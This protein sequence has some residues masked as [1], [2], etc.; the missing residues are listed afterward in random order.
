MYRMAYRS[1]VGTLTFIWKIDQ[2]L[3]D[4]ESCNARAL[5]EVTEILPKYATRDMK[6][7]FIEKY[8]DAAK[9][10]TMVLRSIFQELTEDSSAASSSKEAE[11]DLRAAQFLLYSDHTDI[12][13]DLRS[14]NGQPG[15]TKFDAF[16]DKCQ[17]YF[18][19]HV[20]AVSEQRHGTDY[21]YLPVAISIKDLRQ[22]VKSRLPDLT[23][24]PSSEWLRLLFWPCD[25]DTSRAMHHTGHFNIKFRIQS[26]LVQA[27]HPD[28]KYAA[29]Q[30]KYLKNFAVKFR[31]H[32]LMICLDDKANVPV[33]EPGKPQATGVRGHNRSLAPV[34]GLILSALDYDFH[35]AGIIPSVVFVFDVPSSPLDSFFNGNVFVTSKQ[36]IFEPS[37]PFRHGAEFLRILEDHLYRQ[38]ELRG[39]VLLL[40]TDGGPDHRLT[41]GSVQ[42]SLLCLFLRLNLDMLIAVRTAPGNSWTNL[43]ERVMPVLN[44]ALQNVALERSRMSPQM[45]SLLKSKSTMA[46]VHSA[47]KHFP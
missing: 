4:H 3:P 21:L 38:A 35:L 5:V 37:S 45:E 34:S 32:C 40:Y 22:Q 30:Y 42:I 20:A 15:S 8:S 18:D 29:V 19:E 10:P 47:S 16:W 36:K 39:K 25:P 23:P 27:D 9:C 7:T 1:A 13:L 2:T 24:I 31:E 6:K 33:G 41:Y 44:L 12:I 28:S 17:K 14:L 46:E 11:G 43:A 26:R